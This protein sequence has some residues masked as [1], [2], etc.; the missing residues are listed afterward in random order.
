[1]FLDQSDDNNNEVDSTDEQNN[2]SNNENQRKYDELTAN[3]T[4]NSTATTNGGDKNSDKPL[5]NKTTIPK[6]PARISNNRI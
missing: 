5:L 6:V 4:I 3:A 1:M 2:K